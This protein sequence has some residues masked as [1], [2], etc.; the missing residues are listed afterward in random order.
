MSK[1][2][3]VV[4]TYEEAENLPKLVGTLEESLQKKEFM[5]IVI[6]DNSP[7]G[8]ADVAEKLNR[9]YGNIVVHRRPRKLGIGSA[10]RDGIKIALSFPNCKHIVTMDAD[11]SHNP[12]DVRRLL[13]EA[14]NADLIQ[15]SRYIKGGK[16]IGWSPFRRA[17]S[18]VSNFLCRLLL[19]THLNEH[20]TYL[21]VYSR[22]CAE[23]VV[24][25][26]HCN[27]YEWAIASILVA[28]DYGFKIQEV[29]ITFI[30]RVHGKSKLKLRDVLMW[31]SY[32]SEIFFKRCLNLKERPNGRSYNSHPF[33][34]EDRPQE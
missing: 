1:V 15:G 29:P 4:P 12:K 34:L 26:V 6:D 25:T 2:C 16:I 11:L 22:K 7:D 27:R 18:Y 5:L 3:V 21:R 19:R 31:S 8:T 23:T 20:T 17:V 24:E 32:L 9:H 13:I 28:K 33:L 30:N 10:T 14:E